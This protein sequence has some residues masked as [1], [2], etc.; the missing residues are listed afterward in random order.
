MLGK[1]EA[2]AYLLPISHDIRPMVWRRHT[3]RLEQVLDE[4]PGLVNV[5]IEGDAPTALFCLPD[6]EAEAAQMAALLLRRGA[7]PS[8]RDD[9][10]KTAADA[11]A[12]RGLD[13][14]AD[15]I[16]S[17]PTPDGARGPA[18]GGRRV[19]RLRL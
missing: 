1:P 18:A 10:G 6:D 15:L 9:A 11:A 16:A 8:I 12:R 19:R 2:F 17:W 7:D 3:S 5:S 13:E 4:Q 14:A